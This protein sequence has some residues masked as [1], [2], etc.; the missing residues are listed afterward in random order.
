MYIVMRTDD[1]KHEIIAI[2]ITNDAESARKSMAADIIKT[3]QALS[4]NIPEAWTVDNLDWINNTNST[5]D[6]IEVMVRADK[7]A[8][9]IYA[10]GIYWTIQDIP[11]ELL[12]KSILWDAVEML[13]KLRAQEI[14]TDR[15]ET[16]G[17]HPNENPEVVQK[18]VEAYLN[19][20]NNGYEESIALHDAE[21]LVTDNHE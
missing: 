8:I 16:R 18:A 15:L 1:I 13:E 12:N 11:M 21:M 2:A 9:N 5:I 6:N 20:R 3:L 19:A 10:C 14:L 7:A 4:D 17:Y